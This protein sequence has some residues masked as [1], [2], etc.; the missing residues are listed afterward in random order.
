MGSRSSQFKIHTF[1]AIIIFWYNFLKNCSKT[2]DSEVESPDKSSKPCHANNCQAT[3][4]SVGASEAS[5]TSER[6]KRSLLKL[7]KPSN[8]PRTSKAKQNKTSKPASKHG[9]GSKSKLK[10]IYR[11]SHIIYSRH[12]S[13]I[14]TTFFNYFKIFRIE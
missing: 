2:S 14:K 11:E 4:R 6:A 1:H 9:G 12:V 8:A 3:S 7:S 10:R 13:F 5:S